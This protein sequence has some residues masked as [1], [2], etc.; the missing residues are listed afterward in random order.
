[1]G[2]CTTCRKVGI[3]GWLAL[4]SYATEE[5]M[6]DWDLKALSAKNKLCRAFKNMFL[7]TA[8]TTRGRGIDDD[9]EGNSCPPPA[10]NVQAQGLS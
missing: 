10:I 4:G 8:G 7:P 1:M 9:K 5:S 6:I 3:S 2:D